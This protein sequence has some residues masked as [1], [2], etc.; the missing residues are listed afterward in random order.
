M[1]RRDARILVGADSRVIEASPEALELL[2]L[3]LDE[4]VALPPGAMSLD[5][6]R[7]ASD[8]FEAA[9]EDGGRPPLV[10]SATIRLA[11]GQLLRL[12]Y[13]IG[14]GP[15]GTVEV[16][17]EHSPEPVGEPPRAFAVGKILSAWRAAERLL[18][19]LEPG[20]PEW[21]A[22]EAETQHFK[23]EYRRLARYHSSGSGQAPAT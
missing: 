15:D 5:Q 18:E 10:G 1:V 21:L 7:E 17:L 20:S 8:G 19:A 22:A 3:S 23:A 2:G 14:S 6:D 13:L 9:W 11:N 4:L 12:R 16:F